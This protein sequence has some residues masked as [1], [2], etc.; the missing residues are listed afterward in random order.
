[1]DKKKKILLLTDGITPFVIGGMQK[2]SANLAKFLTLKGWD[3]TLVHCLDHTEKIPDKEEVNR[4]LFGNS[5]VVLADQVV[6]H[7]PA[8]GKVPGHYIR[9]SYQYSK[10]IY[11][12][13]KN[14]IGEFDF[15]YAKGFTAWE[16]IKRKSKGDKS[17]PPIGV[18][19]HGYEMFQ[20]PP[21]FKVALEH[22]LFKKPVKWN[23]QNADLVFSY[24]GKITDIVKSIGVDHS[25][26]VGI[27][28]GIDPEWIKSEVQS[29][30][31]TI[32]FVY[33]GRYERR[34]GIEELM[35]ALRNIEG[36]KSFEFNF[37]GDIPSGKREK[38]SRFVYHGQIGEKDKL[39]SILDSCDVLVCPSHS[40]GM[41]NVILEGMARGLAI[42]ATDTGAVQMMVDE[43]V[44]V[45]LPSPDVGLISSA[46]EKMISMSKEELLLLRN[47][48]LQRIKNEFG[49]D[50]IAEKVISAI[51]NVTTQ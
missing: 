32:R 8:P 45:L 42:I 9:R 48:S 10:M 12:K 23:N 21:S 43:K 30:N 34:K 47:N 7:F 27:T 35:L 14:R 36:D 24:G 18:K 26:I 41:P 4:V 19:F 16:L 37:I 20:T 17:I 51:E 15:I 29:N 38:D 11:E 6:F 31:E 39:I 5:G 1:M 13:L 22:K 25:K 28:S 2:H 40:E 3:I 46:I 49:W 44:G 33:L 50:R